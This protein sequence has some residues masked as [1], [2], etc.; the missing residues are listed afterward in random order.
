MDATFVLPALVKLLVV[1]CA[2]QAY[3]LTRYLQSKPHRCTWQLLR[4][5]SSAECVLAKEHAP[6]ILL[7][8]DD[9]D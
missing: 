5:S 9:H 4:R 1:F 7:E 8:V 2:R 3:A 6:D